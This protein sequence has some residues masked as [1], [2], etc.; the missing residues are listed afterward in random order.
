MM[1][2]M[3]VPIP[4]YMTD[5][6]RLRASDPSVS[7]MS[8]PGA[9]AANLGQPTVPSATRR[10]SRRSGWSDSTRASQ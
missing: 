5:S 8:A 2:R 10:S 1:I 6:V 3:S 7:Q 9:V 4:M